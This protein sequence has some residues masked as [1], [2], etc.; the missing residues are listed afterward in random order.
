MKYYPVFLNLTGKLCVV[1]GGGDVAERKVNSLLESDASVRVISPLITE[2]LSGL[3]RDGSITH[4]HRRY[5]KS[6]LEGA[7]LVIA[8]TSDMSVN[9][10]VSADAEDIPVNIVDVPDLC[11]FIVPSVV[12]RGPLTL[13]VSTS[14]V[15]P[16]LS[17]S[18]RKELEQLYTDDMEG[19]LTCVA[20]I[21]KKLMQSDLPPDERS[22]LLKSLGSRKI[23][24]ALRE[25]GVDK[26]CRYAES[27]LL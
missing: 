11:S 10:Q 21:R 22:A 24:E 9:K 14:G 20:G 8:A 17:K 15:S 23:L 5:K 19:Y 13:A 7:F 2:G 3:S 12:K 27:L 25:E 26:A 4:I 6:D 16:A 18:I 1:V